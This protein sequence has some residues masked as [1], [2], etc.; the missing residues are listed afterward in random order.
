MIKINKTLTL[1]EF[2]YNDVKQIPYATGELSN[3]LRDFSLAVKR[4][5]VEVN[6]AGLLDVLGTSGLT[7]IQNEEVMKLDDI[8]NTHIFNVLSSGYSCAG[9]ASEELDDIMIFD[10]PANNQSKYILLYDPIDGSSNI[11]TNVSIG[12]IFSIYRRISK[13][14]PDSPCTKEDFLQPGHQIIASGY[15]IYG[16]STIFVFATKRGVN[17][18]TLDPTIGEFCL[19]HPNIQCPQTGSIISF[20]MANYYQFTQP[21]RDYLKKFLTDKTTNL[22]HR[23]IGSLVAD[24]HRNL[25]KGG[26]FLYPS[27]LAHKNGKLRLQYECNPMAFIFQQAG[28]VAT[29]GLEAILDIIPTELHQRVPIIIGSPYFFK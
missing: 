8:A 20:N 7:N 28:G 10:N 2:R 17:G 26:L 11:D 6:K 18:F 13:P 16:S 3:L 4:I 12:S 27:T 1:E 22:S 29:T 19:S 9:V 25:I 21:T 14:A 5:N 24:L 23:Y 15:V